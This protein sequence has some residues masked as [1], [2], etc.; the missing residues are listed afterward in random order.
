MNEHPDPM[1]PDHVRST[2]GQDSLKPPSASADNKRM[3]EI[4]ASMHQLIDHVV[5]QVPGVLGTLVSSADGLVL[6]SRVDHNTGLDAAAI[7]AMSA[8]VLGLSN[9]LVQLMGAAPTSF[10]HQR[11]ADGQVFVFGISSVAVLTVL[12]DPTAQPAQIQSVGREIGFGLERLF[13]GSANV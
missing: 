4:D 9:R 7:A 2:D 11:S 12:A 5:D 1:G 8:A 10:S 3:T 6:A 13:S